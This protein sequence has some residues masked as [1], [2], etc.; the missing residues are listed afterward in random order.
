GRPLAGLA[1]LLLAALALRPQV[2]G[3][4]PLFP[5]I[6]HDLGASHAVV[7]LLGT[8]PVLCMG[9]FAPP[10]AFLASLLGTGRA[11]AASLACVGV[12]GLLRAAAPEMWQIVVLTFPVG[13][14]MGLSGA[15][16]PVAVKERFADRAASATGLYTM[17][18]QIGSTGAAALAV[19]IA[20]WL[21]GWRWALA[22]FS[23]G[24]LLSTVTWVL[25]ETRTANAPPTRVRPPRL[26]WRSPVALLLTLIFALMGSG[27]YG[28][29]AWLADAYTE[30]GW[31][32]GRAGALLACLTLTAIPTSLLVPWLS[33]RF[34]TRQALLASLSFVYAG[35]AAGLVALPS[36]A[37]GLVLLAGLAQGGLFS[38]VLTLPLDIGRRPGEVGA[39]IGI[40]LGGGYCLAALS[41]FVLG[42]VRDVTGSFNGPL[43]VA[44]GLL[45]S[46][47]VA[48]LVLP[49]VRARDSAFAG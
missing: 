20:A 45:A 46:Q 33:E 48:V 21:G 41:P 49:T 30:L 23:V 44:A 6:E 14:G 42:A 22:A 26:P 29:N 24:A 7:G 28:L 15:L 8:I 17:G 2:V 10:A 4:G 18:I 39:L 32:E 11:I 34:F 43:W 12:F 37:W 1:A 40:M 9:L 3:A 19:P 27:Y 47:V 5:D 36:L 13:M 38:L 16:I 35:A 25:L 31:S